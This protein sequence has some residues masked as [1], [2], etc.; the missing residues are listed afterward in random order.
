M[1]VGGCMT[2]LNYKNG[3]FELIFLLHYF[4]ISH[5]I[6]LRMCTSFLQW[7]ATEK[8]WETLF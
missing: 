8:D 3:S 2:I 6:L 7:A 1:T 4:C 5:E